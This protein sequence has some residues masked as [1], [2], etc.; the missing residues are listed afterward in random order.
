[1]V[2]GW[3][4]AKIEIQDLLLLRVREEITNSGDFIHLDNL[5]S[6]P[7]PRLVLQQMKDALDL[8]HLMG[9]EEIRRSYPNL[10]ENIYRSIGKLINSDNPRED[11]AIVESGIGAWATILTSVPLN[12]GDI[13]LLTKV[14]SGSNYL[15]ILHYARCMGADVMYVPSE[16]NGSISLVAFKS[17]L[18]SLSN[19]RIVC[20][21]WIPSN[22][23][24]PNDISECSNIMSAYPTV[25][26][27][28]DASQAVGHQHIDVTQLRCHFLTGS[29]NHYLRSPHGVDFLYIS[30]GIIPL[31]REPSTL[32][33]SSGDFTDL[34]S[35]T[36]ASS[37]RRY[38]ILPSNYTL[39]I[40]FQASLEYYLSLS[41]ASL[42]PSSPS[43]SSSE[44]SSP[45]P[46]FYPRWSLARLSLLGNLLLSSFNE[47]QTLS[48]DRD[49]HCRELIIWNS[50][51]VSGILCFTINGLSCQQIRDIFRTRNI[52]VSICR[53]PEST[54]LDALERR[55]PDRVRISIHYFNTEI[56]IFI[57]C[58]VIKELIFEE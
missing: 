2:C 47:L 33:L 28:I 45:P 52:F 4:M 8:E 48:Q 7:V 41:S 34:Q 24:T 37:A 16:P 36:I 43:T 46:S 26:Y 11:I 21:T 22:G 58:D 3:K 51:A 18:E 56:E 32:N 17:M 30:P 40:G 49:S 55:L 12:K 6:A 5:H 54:Y 57:L 35:Y 53:H 15:N 10:V 13:I 44:N 20:L 50:S 1:M 27:L 14:E 38:Q 31:L 25:L 9:R 39:L 23:A 42:S 19:I 29:G